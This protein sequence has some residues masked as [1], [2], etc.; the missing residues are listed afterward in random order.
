MVAAGP[1]KTGT[2][3]PPAGPSSDLRYRTSH[4]KRTAFHDI[5]IATRYRTEPCLP[6]PYMR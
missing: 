2:P 5:D 4:P 1:N 3:A 6:G